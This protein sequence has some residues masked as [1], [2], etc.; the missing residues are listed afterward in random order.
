MSIVGGR[1]TVTICHMANRDRGSIA[2]NRNSVT[3]ASENVE[4]AH[5]V[6]LL[7]VC[8]LQQSVIQVL[9]QNEY[10]KSSTMDRQLSFEASCMNVGFHQWRLRGASGKIR[11]IVSWR[12]LQFIELVFWSNLN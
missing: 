2:D 7:S 1:H 9:E 5:S 8:S 10:V 6:G 3:S 12:K 4:Q 11:D